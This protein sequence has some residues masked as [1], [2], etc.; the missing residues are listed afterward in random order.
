MGEINKTNS[1]TEFFYKAFRNIL[2]VSIPLVIISALILSLPHSSAEGNAS[3]DI[4]K[5]DNISLTLNVS[6]TLSATELT[7]HNITLEG[8]G[9]HRE[10]IGS[11]KVG[12]FCNDN[13]G[14]NIYA[15]GHS[16]NTDGNTDLVVNG[17][18]D[19][20]NIKT[21][22]YSSGGT[23]SS[24]GMK[25]TAGTGTG[26][27]SER[28][29]PTINNGYNNY[30]VIPNVYTMVASRPS[31]T[32]MDKD[33]NPDITGSYFTTTYD[34]YASSVQPAGTYN[35]KV[36]YITH[37]NIN[38]PSTINDIEAAFAVN[39]KQ[40]SHLGTDGNYYYAMQD[41]TTDICNSVTRT[42]KDTATQLIDI[43]DHKLYWV[44][45][46]ADG[47]SGKCWMT[48]NLD[49][50]IGG[51]NTT[52]LNSN[53]TDI[54]TNSNA[55][56]GA[57]IYSD[58][59]VSNGVYTWNPDSTAVTSGRTITYPNNTNNPT[60]SDWNDNATKPYSAEGGDTY[61]YTSNS[62][63]ND[64]RYTSLK[65]CT[66]AH[67]AEAECER[68]FAGNYYNWTA[69]IASNNSTNISTNNSKAA[70]SICPKGWR[71]P[72]ASQTDNEYNE[73]G[74]LLFNAGITAA[75]SNGNNSVGYAND[76]FNKLRS[77]PY[78]F[79]RSGFIYSSALN[80]S[81]ITGDYWSGTVSSN[82]NAYFMRFNSRDVLP[83]IANLRPAGRSIR[84]IARQSELP[85][86][87]PLPHLHPI[88]H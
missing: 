75:L 80:N 3:G 46:L 32:N 19:D 11:T 16:N 54:S 36:K 61:Y 66:T 12:V 6:C 86:H 85:R 63:S 57:G 31:G 42:G 88:I 28:T 38:A 49:L 25:L 22:V 39:G 33:A 41:M 4:T 70:N 81:C 10:N 17:L 84:C 58:Y 65:D 60:V 56:T 9:L 29:P 23:I 82:T 14:Y 48:S 74:R 72:N 79:V 47:G 30:N 69:A 87:Q 55:Y 18:S 59:S 64:T 52:P 78:Y 45:K 73:F 13:N 83:A 67:P 62:T 40:K 43:R 34:I 35:G 76:G 21:G 1:Y 20:Y 37:P 71:L 51:T 44:A 50:D 5:V 24:W 53:N 7:P 68:Y 27:E 15:V 8:S 77:S 2:L 26:S